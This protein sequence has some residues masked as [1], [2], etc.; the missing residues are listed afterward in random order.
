MTYLATLVS[1]L[2]RQVAV[3]GEFA[4]SFPN[5]I[6]ADLVGSLADGFAQAQMDGFFGSQ[7]LDLNTNAVTPDLS[8]GGSAIVALYAAEN[9]LTAKFRNQP[10]RTV[11]KAGTVQYE[12]DMSANVL[13][14]E[15]KNMAARR[16]QLLTVALRMLRASTPSIYM[17]DAYV[18]RSFGFLPFFSGM[19]MNGFGF[20]AYEL[21]GPW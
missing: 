4:T 16:V 17:N 1:G 9:I 7:L 18:T 10:T 13:A 2:K 21:T 6:D 19:D 5:T 15:I 3:P 12:V 20:W 14:A 8:A 11:Y